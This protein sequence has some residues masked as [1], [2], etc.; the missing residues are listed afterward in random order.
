MP[1]LADAEIRA[2]ILDAFSRSESGDGV[3]WTN[4][5]QDRLREFLPRATQKGIN[6]SL[7]KWVERGGEISQAVETRAEYR[8]EHDFH[9][10]F[11]IR[12]GETRY[13]IEGILIDDRRDDPEFQVV[14][15]KPVDSTE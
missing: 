2:K 13:Y 14:N 1:P 10:D 6:R 15:F 7:R 9:Y 8:E 11:R 12:I 5:A 4:L 3:L